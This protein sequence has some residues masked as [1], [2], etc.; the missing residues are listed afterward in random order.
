[1]RKKI[2]LILCLISLLSVSAFAKN[3]KFIA[4]KYVLHDSWAYFSE[5]TNRKAD[6]FFVC[7]TVYTGKERNMPFYDKESRER[8]VGASNMILGI[9]SENCRLYVPFYSQAGLNTYKNSRSENEAALKIA[10]ADVKSAFLCYM[11]NYNQGRPFVLAGFSQGA[12]MCLRLMKE[13]LAEPKYS[14]KL[15]AAYLLGWRVTEDDLKEYPQ[16]K[17]AKTAYDTGVV[18]SF[19]TEAPEITTSIIVPDKTLGI[20]P[21][22]WKTT[23]EVADKS[24]NRG[25]CFTDYSG[26]ALKIIPAFTGAYLDAERGTLKVTDVDETQYPPVLEMMPIGVYHFYDYQ[27]FYRNLQE[28]VRDRVN[29]FLRDNPKFRV[30]S[31]PREE[32]RI[33]IDTIH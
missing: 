30:K 14:D 26:K 33:T 5:G 23:S 3:A 11:D 15:I 2:L 18:V 27:F 13:F 6:V 7:P 12:D 20:N 32:K 28:N 9:Y 16:I 31:N 4:P 22:N 21:L 10:Y 19:N 17:M 8:F 25:A 1:M 24:L 29:V